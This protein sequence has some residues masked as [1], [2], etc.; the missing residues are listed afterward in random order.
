MKGKKQDFKPLEKVKI[1]GERINKKLCD[2]RYFDTFRMSKF[3]K[4]SKTCLI[5]FFLLL[6]ASSPLFG[7]NLL[8]TLFSFYQ[9]YQDVNMLLWLSGDIKAEKRFGEQAKWFIN[10]TNK[11]E[12][13]P[14]TNRWVSSV[15]ERLKP[16]FRDLGLNYNVT[17]IQGNE[18]NAFA[19]PGGSIFVYTGILK[20]VTSDDELAAVLAHELSHAERRHSL[21][22]L[23]TNAAFQLLL[24]KAVKNKNDRNT[25]GQVVGALTSLQ[26]TREH[27]IEA[28]T[29]GQERMARAG[30]NPAAQVLLWEKFVQK[31]GTGDKGLLKYLGT[32]PP[33]QER[34]ERARRGLAKLQ[35]AEQKDFS[36]SVNILANTKEN[37]LQNSSFESD[38]K[39]INFP[40]AW[41]IKEGKSYPTSE[42]S[43]TGK[44]S[45][46]LCA[47]NQVKSVRV[48][49]E[50]IPVSTSESYLLTGWMR[51]QDGSQK[52][53]VGAEIYDKK[54]KLLGFIWPVVSKA[55]VSNNWTP[56]EGVFQP[57]SD[58]MKNLPPDTAF[59]KILLQNGP[60]S[61]GEIWFDD[62]RLKKTATKDEPNLITDGDFEYTEGN[63]SPS[64]INGTTDSIA[65]D[66]EKFR[67][68]YAS[69]LIS[70]PIEKDIEIEFKPISTKDIPEKKNFKISWSYMG[71]D[72]INAQIKINSIQDGGK[73]LNL[74]EKKLLEKEFVAKP[75]LWENN[76]ADFEFN[77]SNEERQRI[78]SFSVKICTHMK[79]GQKLWLDNFVMR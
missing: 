12:K 8:G 37:L 43:L 1:I 16:H 17:V 36:L 22:I 25:W 18:V 11:K 74:S 68:G 20:L 28:D 29:M 31:F 4:F 79:E 63:G 34:V 15:F 23:R 55:P 24:Q 38:V 42:V 56:F 2:N 5:L 66:L 65:R 9:T 13:N 30:F 61:S 57:G 70:P 48:V 51:S 73:L 76:S 41:T 33:S 21:Q 3:S 64:G 53:S 78:N 45:L 46:C 19:I 32:H 27:E 75:N 59:I 58:K 62:L 60:I 71:S 39:N 6:S 14:E 54:K 50:W 44:K 35:V 10:L 7:G 69:L 26:F 52:G 72:S 40:D 77:L 47:E 67:T 49:S